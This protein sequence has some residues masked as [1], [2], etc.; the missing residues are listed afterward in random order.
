MSSNTQTSTPLNLMDTN[1]PESQT[2]KASKVRSWAK[3]NFFTKKSDNLYVCK[4]CYIDVKTYNNS[5]KRLIDH[6]K[7]VHKITKQDALLSKFDAAKK[8]KLDFDDDSDFD[9]EIIED[10][11][12]TPTNDKSSAK[13]KENINK[14]LI[15]FILRNNLSFNLVESE[16]FQE[17]FDAVRPGFY[18]LPCRQ[19]V[20]NTFLPKMVKFKKKNFILYYSLFY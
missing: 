13:Q 18:S 12:N 11:N 4:K 8:R 20:R 15:N 9:E 1:A 10:N 17:L 2:H 16:E 14:K 7:N 19:T 6:L 3:L 5:S